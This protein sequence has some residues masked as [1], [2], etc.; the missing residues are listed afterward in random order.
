MIA[1]HPRGHCP[2]AHRL[3]IIDPAHRTGIG[4]AAEMRW[5]GDTIISEGMDKAAAQ[6]IREKGL[7]SRLNR[8]L[9]PEGYILFYTYDPKKIGDAEALI[10]LSIERYVPK[11]EGEKQLAVI[12]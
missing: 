2:E 9:I 12:G 6:E 4:W 7:L 1:A 11:D 5:E 10:G 8:V 3:I